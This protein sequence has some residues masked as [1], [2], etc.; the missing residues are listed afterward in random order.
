VVKN[1]VGGITILLGLKG[2]KMR[3]ISLAQKY[4]K[5]GG[6]QSPPVP[7]GLISLVDEQ[8]PVVARLVPLKVYHGATWFLEGKWIIQLNANDVSAAKRFTT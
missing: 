2:H 3:K 4:V 1:Q 5:M 8:Y 7:T 6:I